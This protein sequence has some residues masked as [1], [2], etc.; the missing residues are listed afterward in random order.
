[1]AEHSDAVNPLGPTHV[2][3]SDIAF[4]H[5]QVVAMTK[6]SGS[7]DGYGLHID[8]VTNIG[9][10]PVCTTIA[11]HA[12]DLMGFAQFVMNAAETALRNDASSN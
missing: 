3:T 11:F 6:G 7:V 2:C 10:K 5:V 9:S 1:M 4:T 12:P 8:G